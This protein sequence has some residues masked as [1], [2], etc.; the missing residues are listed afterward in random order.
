[1]FDDRYTFG[2][3]IDAPFDDVRESVETALRAEGF[4][5]LT[6][7]DVAATLRAK[8]GVVQDPYVILG[9]C[10]PP[11]AHRAISADPAVGVLLPCNVVIRDVGDAVLV[12]AM[13]PRAAMG[14]VDDAVVA[15]VAAEARAKL[16]RAVAAI[17]QQYPAEA[18]A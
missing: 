12:E 9:A 3:R 1:M 4:G 17:E 14:L 5:V 8:L 11:L 15:E 10:N 7:I 18:L 16:V 2:A 6:E 13:D